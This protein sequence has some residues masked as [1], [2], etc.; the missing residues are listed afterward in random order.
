M[1]PL[2][3]SPAQ[4]A[5]VQGPGAKTFLWWNAHGSG[6]PPHHARAAYQWRVKVGSSQY[7][8]NYF[9]GTPVNGGQLQAT[10]LFQ[11]IPP[12]GAT[13][14]TVVEWNTAAGGLWYAGTPTSFT[15]RA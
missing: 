6:Q 2:M 1:P 13:C 4:G 7:G 14:W 3:Q 9:L 5:E 11:S 15:Y 12:N 10:V 8:F